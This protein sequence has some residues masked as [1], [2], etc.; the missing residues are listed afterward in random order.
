MKIPLLTIAVLFSCLTSLHAE[1]R[2]LLV[3]IGEYPADSG[4]PIILGPPNDVKLMKRLLMDQFGVKEASI[5]TLTDDQATSQGIQNAFLSHL[6]RDAKPEDVVL[7]YFAGHGTQLPDFGPEIDETDGQDEALVTY[8][9]DPDDKVQKTWLTDD[10]LY[11][12]LQAVPARHVI[13]MFDCCHAGSGTRGLDNP[14]PWALTRSA[15]VGIPDVTMREKR[16]PAHQ[17]FLAAC[18]PGELAHGMY[19]QE[20]EAEVGVFTHSF[21]QLA[22]AKS[23]ESDLEA[24]QTQLRERVGAEVTKRSRYLVQR[25]VVE[26]ARRDASLGAFVKGTVFSS[27]APVPVTPA[28]PAPA[29]GVLTGFT[30]VGSLKVTL[31]TDQPDYVWT[32]NMVVTASVDREAYLRIYHLD[33]AGNL[34]QLYPNRLQPMRKHAAGEIVRLPPALPATA[35][36]YDLRVGGPAQGLEVLIAVASTEPFTDAEAKVFAAEHFNVIPDTS[37]AEVMTRGIEVRPREET[38]KP[39]ATGQA[40]RIYRVSQFRK[41]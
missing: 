10:M 8:D 39:V 4:Y 25:P 22:A 28:A 35:E 19:S 24:L 11:R 21:C 15:T 16:A 1:V 9:F 27:S 3:G 17:V 20:L 14:F 41:P 38:P 40:I 29:P 7:F 6:I 30:P 36:N 34:A 2:A 13:V 5:V 31:A 12:H 18:E 26:A 37:P 23:V 32:E 33:S